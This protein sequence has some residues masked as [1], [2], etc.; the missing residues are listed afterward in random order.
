[1][2]L[3]CRV[4]FFLLNV[5]NLYASNHLFDG[6]PP[7]IPSYGLGQV[8]DNRDDGYLAAHLFISQDLFREIRPGI[9]YHK[10]NEIGFKKSMC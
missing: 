10:F 8:G 1:V 2:R 7:Q 4:V 9:G 5:I 6:I 3:S